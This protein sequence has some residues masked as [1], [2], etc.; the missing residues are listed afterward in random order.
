MSTKMSQEVK[1]KTLLSQDDVT[2]A[3]K[4]FIEDFPVPSNAIPLTPKLKRIFDRWFDKKVKGEKNR[5]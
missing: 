1:N 5:K 3:F 4:R 2:P